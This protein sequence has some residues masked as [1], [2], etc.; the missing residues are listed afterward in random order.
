MKKIAVA[1]VAVVAIIGALFLLLN[2]AFPYIYAESG[3]ARYAREH[4]GEAMAEILGAAVLCW[5]AWYCIRHSL[6][7]RTWIAIA[8]ILTAVAIVQGVTAY[9]RAPEGV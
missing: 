5:L 4:Q 7:G 6:S 9:Y 2:A 3:S 1:L 8:G